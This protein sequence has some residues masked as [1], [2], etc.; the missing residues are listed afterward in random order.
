MA[1]RVTRSVAVI[2]QKEQVEDNLGQVI[3]LEKEYS[4]AEVGSHYIP[5][6]SLRFLEAIFR[7]HLRQANVHQCFNCKQFVLF[8]EL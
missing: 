3:P 4:T 8:V 7:R 2:S 5:R 1:K 6:P